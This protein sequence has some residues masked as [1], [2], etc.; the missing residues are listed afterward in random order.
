MNEKNRKSYAAVENNLLENPDEIIGARH[1]KYNKKEKAYILKSSKKEKTKLGKVVTEETELQNTLGTFELQFTTK[2][3]YAQYSEI[4]K[5]ITDVIGIS[6][7]SDFIEID[8]RE[9]KDSV[10]KETY[11]KN[12]MDEQGKLYNKCLELGANVP[13]LEKL[14][15]LGKLTD[16]EEQICK[17][18]LVMKNII[19]RLE[20]SSLL[21]LSPKE[22][23][24]TKMIALYYHL[25]CLENSV[26]VYGNDE[27]EWKSFSSVYNDFSYCINP[28]LND[29]GYQEISSKNIYD[30]FVIF[31]AYCEINNFLAD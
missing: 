17:F 20:P 7:F 24:R 5:F 3:A 30:V 4:I 6:S 25:Y 18:T 2:T 29:S 15:K 23:S 10:E 9:Y 13:V 21:S 22:L 31:L 14:L 26:G 8:G 1:F 28:Y 16:S 12:Y 19:N 11:D 27:D